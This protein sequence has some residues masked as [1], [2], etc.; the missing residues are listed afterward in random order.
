GP[1]PGSP[2]EESRIVRSF[3]VAGRSAFTLSGSVH[4]NTTAGDD[5]LDQ[6]L[7]GAR[8]VRVTSSSRYLDN[9][10]FRASAAFDGNSET[11]WVPAGGEGQWLAANFPSQRVSR[12]TIDTSTG[13][14]RASI[15]R[16]KVVL[17]DG[18]TRYG[19]VAD[20]T[21]G[22]ITITFPPRLM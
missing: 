19:T 22:V 13:P 10:A 15:E 5:Q 17:P 3:Q 9:V 1:S 7:F 8:S 16:I 18:T 6:A 21:T 2:D 11:E 4:L 20:P 12:I 14:T